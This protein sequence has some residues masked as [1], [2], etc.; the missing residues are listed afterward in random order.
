[1]YNKSFLLW[2]PIPPVS[3]SLMLKMEDFISF[4]ETAKW[5]YLSV[6]FLQLP[7]PYKIYNI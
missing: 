1:M 6:F 2:Q 3:L 7:S 5:W 4:S